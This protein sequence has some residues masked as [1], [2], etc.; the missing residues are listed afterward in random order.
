MIVAFIRSVSSRFT[1]Q[2]QPTT[3]KQTSDAVAVAQCISNVF[4]QMHKWPKQHK[5]KYEKKVMQFS[6]DARQRLNATLHLIKPK[7][8]INTAEPRRCWRDNN[9]FSSAMRCCGE[10]TSD[11][12]SPWSSHISIDVH[13]GKLVININVC[14]CCIIF[15][16]RC[17]NEWCRII[18]HASYGGSKQHQQKS[19]PRYLS[20]RFMCGLCNIQ[21]LCANL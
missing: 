2:R 7:E 21:H 3:G 13:S 5:Q 6:L 8:Q 10:H 1:H 9:V 15:F 11:A 17:S 12:R 14:C 18:V 20:S 19:W 4:L 16:V